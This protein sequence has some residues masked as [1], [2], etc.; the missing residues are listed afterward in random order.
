MTAV[1]L[2]TTEVVINIIFLYNSSLL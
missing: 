2:T 1:Y